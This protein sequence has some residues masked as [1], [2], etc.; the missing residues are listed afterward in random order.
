M[1]KRINRLCKLLFGYSVI[2][3]LLS[4]CGMIHISAEKELQYT[5]GNNDIFD[6]AIVAARKIGYSQIE[7]PDRKSGTFGAVKVGQTAV[8][9]VYQANFYVSK[10]NHSITMNIQEFNAMVPSTEEQL[11]GMIAIYEKE[12]EKQCKVKVSYG[13]GR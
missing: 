13:D 9:A 11:K 5:P 7:F 1:Q 8:N 3:V 6:C 10:E 2:M 12:F 4:S